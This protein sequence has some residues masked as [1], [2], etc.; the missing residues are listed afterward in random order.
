MFTLTNGKY[1]SYMTVLRNKY[2]SISLN[3]KITFRQVSTQE[4]SCHPFRIKS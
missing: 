1:I 4:K 3:G 2:L